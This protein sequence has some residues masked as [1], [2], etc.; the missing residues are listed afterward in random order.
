MPAGGKHAVFCKKSGTEGTC[1]LW[2]PGKEQRLTQLALDHFTTPLYFFHPLVLINQLMPVVAQS[3]L[4]V[5]EMLSVPQ[6][7]PHF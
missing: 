3:V 6:R 7:S 1:Q 2:L 5:L 4:V